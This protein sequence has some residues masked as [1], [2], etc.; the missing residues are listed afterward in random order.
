MIGLD[1]RLQGA[2]EALE[3]GAAQ[4][5][6]REVG[7][8]ERVGGARRVVDERPL[9]DELRVGDLQMWGMWGQMWGGRR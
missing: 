8:G 3:V 1:G 5:H 4:L 9:A 2:E 6:Q 7:E